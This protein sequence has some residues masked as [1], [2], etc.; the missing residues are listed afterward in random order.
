[1]FGFGHRSP[2]THDEFEFLRRQ[3]VERQI[4]ARG[5]CQERVLA[6]M[7]SV[8]RHCFV[9]LDRIA[10][11]YADVPLPIGERQTISQPFMVA[12]MADALQLNGRERVLE[13][14]AGS[15]YQAAVLSLLAREVIA[16]ESRPQLASNARER[17]ARLG[18]ANV[19][20]EC[21]D[22]SLGWQAAA[23]YDA[24]IVSCAAPSVPQPLLDQLVEAGRL[25]VPVGDAESQQ[26]IRLTR[27]GNESLREG[28]YHCRFVPLVGRHGWPQILEKVAGE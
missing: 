21:G 13:I 25:V 28:L 10:D 9:R 18:F 20:V 4:R 8:P 22:G 17:L 2:E 23:P 19:R 3:M 6:A 14:G 26:V 5:I 24:I 15:G 1:M 7:A 11:A 27:R 16:I 12:A